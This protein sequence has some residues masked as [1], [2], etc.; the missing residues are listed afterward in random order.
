MVQYK[1]LGN[2]VRVKVYA[3]DANLKVFGATA[4][5]FIDNIGADTYRALAKAQGLGDIDRE[6]W[7]PLQPIFDLFNQVVEMDTGSTQSFVAMGLRIAEQ[8]AFPPELQND[9]T[10]IGI[11]EGW[12]SHYAANH[13][14]APL[15]P[16]TTHRISDQHYELHLLPEHLYPYDLVYGMAYGFC[17]LLLPAGSHFSVTYKANHSPYEDDA[18]EKTIIVSVRWT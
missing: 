1:T 3:C 12:M 13:Q 8:S 17:R 14:G 16:V 9:R 6:S 15:P 4:L 18:Q 10:L 7:V 2:G 11:L 5:S